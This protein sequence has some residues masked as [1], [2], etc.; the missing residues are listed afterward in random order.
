MK[1]KMYR[2]VKVNIPKNTVITD[3]KV[4]NKN[5]FAVIKL[6]LEDKYIPKNGDYVFCN[7]RE[8]SVVAVF[9]YGNEF[10]FLPYVGIIDKDFS[11][12]LIGGRLKSTSIHPIRGSFRKATEEE[13]EMYTVSLN[14]DFNL[15]WVPDKKLV[16][17]YM[18]IPKDRQRYYYIDQFY[19]I[20]SNI[21]QG[22]SKDLANIACYNCF[23]TKKF[24]EDAYAEN[25]KVFK[26]FNIESY[27]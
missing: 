22:T 7:T 14:K 4:E 8:G 21:Y 3:T 15:M 18:W 26:K 9:N 25:Q 10:S 1:N 19:G 5:G 17:D 12:E 23:K 27:E 20:M 24:A 6:T 13:I 16:I 11:V 2:E